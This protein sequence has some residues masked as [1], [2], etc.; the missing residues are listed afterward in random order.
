M[1]SQLARLIPAY[2][3][4]GLLLLSLLCPA[5]SLQAQ[6]PCSPQERDCVELGRWQFSLAVGLGVRTNP[7]ADGDD[8]PLPLLPRL[9]YTGERFFLDNLDMGV[10]LWGD[11]QQQLNVLL[12]PGYDQLFFRRWH[13]LNIFINGPLGSAESLE[14]GHTGASS[15]DFLVGEEKASNRQAQQKRKRR[16]AALGGLEYQY[17]LGNSWLQLQ[18]L[19]ELTN[20]YQGEE[21][22][23]VLGY[24]WQWSR[25][26]L[27]LAAGLLWQDANT[28]NHYYG[29]APGEVGTL[30][31]YQAE[32]GFSPML[33]MDWN[34]R[35]SE[36]WD[37][38]AS[39]SYRQLSD[40]ISASPLVRDD[41][42]TSLFLGGVYHF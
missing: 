24:D 1:A 6:E 21:R 4:H 14:G 23:L 2:L 29:V 7:L 5:V 27:T 32:S 35:L 40:S 30:Y 22:R 3:V 19:H 20:Y 38:T 31:Q 39:A 42:I 18:W 34:Y 10:Q 16:F 28:L 17:R 41:H 9:S 25:Q 37:L 11:G 15:D 8:I 36:R 26:Q 12:T 13:P 33:R